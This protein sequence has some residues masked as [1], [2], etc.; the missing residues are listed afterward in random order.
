[1]NRWKIRSLRTKDKVVLSDLSITNLLR[2]RILAIVDISMQPQADQPLRNLRRVLLL[3]SSR[4]N[5]ISTHG[6]LP[7]FIPKDK[8]KKRTHIRS[9][10]R[11][12]QHLPRA[13]PKRPLA[14]K[15]L[16]N[17][18]QKP[19]QTPQNRPMYNNRPIRSLIRTPILQIEPLRQLEVQLYRRTLETPLQRIPNRDINF[20]SVERPVPRVDLPFARIMLLQRLLELLLRLVP[21]LNRAQVIIRARRKLQL[22]LEPEQPV[23]VLHEVEQGAD[24]VLELRGHAEDVRVVLHEPPHAREPG[25]RA[26]RFVAVDDPE[27]GHPDGELFVAPVARVED[28]AV[29]R[30]VHGFQRPFLL[31]D[32]QNEHVILVVLPVTRGLPEF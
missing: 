28:E 29:A 6:P 5:P 31:L 4:K 25:E 19:L 10:N 20:R 27:F 1:M 3:Q 11:N 17:N 18:R 7:T 21:R 32:V 15:M 16:R 9:R 30:A 26:A 14:R 13:Q 23:D 8:E 2:Q 22:E 12:D 24:L